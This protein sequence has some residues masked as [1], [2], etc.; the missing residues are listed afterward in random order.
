MRDRE[1]RLSGDMSGQIN[2]SSNQDLESGDKIQ[3]KANKHG[4]SSRTNAQVN[5]D[6]TDQ[7]AIDEIGNFLKDEK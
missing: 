3:P 7:N 4:I 2:S 6:N 1:K 5:D